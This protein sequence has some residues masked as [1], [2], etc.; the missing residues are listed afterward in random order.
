MWPLTRKRTLTGIRSNSVLPF[1][2]RSKNLH[3]FA[4][5]GLSVQKKIASVRMARVIRSKKFASV[6]ARQG[7]SVQKNLHPF[8]HDLGYQFKKKNAP[9][10]TAGELFSRWSIQKN[11]IQQFARLG[12]SVI[13]SQP[14]FICS[15]KNT[16]LSLPYKQ[17]RL[18]VQSKW[19]IMKPFE[20]L[21][22]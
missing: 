1:T 5:L 3:P 16:Y 10:R 20:R 13:H 19:Q 12:L 15:E 14:L 2:C 22:M 18:P 11:I 8:S 6:L 21:R 4:R 17:V 9:A 7:S